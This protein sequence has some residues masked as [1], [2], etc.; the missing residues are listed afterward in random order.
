MRRYIGQ[1][2]RRQAAEPPEAAIRLSGT[3]W[4]VWIDLRR[5]SDQAVHGH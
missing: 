2:P 4:L 1:L 5:K 3:P